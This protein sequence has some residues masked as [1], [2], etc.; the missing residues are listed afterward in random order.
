M[1][2][3]ALNYSL[4]RLWDLL[5][6]YFFFGLGLVWP[7]FRHL[8][9]QKNSYIYIYIYFDLILAIWPDFWYRVSLRDTTIY[10]YLKKKKILKWSHDMSLL[11]SHQ[12]R[13]LQK[14]D[15]FSKMA[16][17]FKMMA[18]ADVIEGTEIKW[19]IDKVPFKENN[20]YISSTV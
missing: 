15:F 12:V 19:S 13:Y 2:E 18:K 9:P 14:L 5:Y 3:N 10:I 20:K 8:K 6:I 16:L 11:K 1:R 7:G 4:W 17:F